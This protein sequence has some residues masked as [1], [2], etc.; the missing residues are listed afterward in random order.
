M[1]KQHAEHDD[2]TC[3]YCRRQYAHPNILSPAQ[4]QQLRKDMETFLE[5]GRRSSFDIALKVERLAV[6]YGVSYSTVY[7]LTKEARVGKLNITRFKSLL[8]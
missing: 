3:Y 1:Q 4:K 8:R 7:R 2:A 5:E 6:A